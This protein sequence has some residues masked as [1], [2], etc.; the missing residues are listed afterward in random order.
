V[1][2]GERYCTVVPIAIGRFF[3]VKKNNVSEVTPAKPLIN[4][5]FLLFPKNG[6][7]F[8]LMI[9]TQITSEIID[10]KKTT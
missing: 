4:S 9:D 3:K 10:L 2:I 5:H 1:K 7:F 8:V 6:I